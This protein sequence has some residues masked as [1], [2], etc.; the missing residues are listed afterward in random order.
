ML[1]QHLELSTAF[2]RLA[3]EIL[4][5]EEISKKEGM[6]RSYISWPQ[7]PS[8]AALSALSGSSGA[9]L[10]EQLEKSLQCE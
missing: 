4:P 2:S 7:S 5:S 9:A 1:G 3:S 10:P 8:L 6:M